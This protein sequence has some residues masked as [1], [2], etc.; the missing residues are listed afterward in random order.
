MTASAPSSAA[1]LSLTAASCYNR[2][3][4]LPDF[5]D[6]PAASLHDGRGGDLVVLNLKLRVFD[7]AVEVEL[8]A[9]LGTHFDVD[10]LLLHFSAHCG[11]VLCLDVPAHR[12]LL[13]KVELLGCARVVP[14]W[15][16]GSRSRTAAF[17]VK[18]QAEAYDLLRENAGQWFRLETAEGK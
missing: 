18:L 17:K 14:L 4:L 1:A 16:T 2:G 7:E 3:M 13:W 10:D 5:M 6:F 11:K 12:L 8:G 15:R 9:L